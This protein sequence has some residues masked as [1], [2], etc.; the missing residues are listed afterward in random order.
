M[1]SNPKNE[2]HTFIKSV[3]QNSDID[4]VGTNSVDHKL[5]CYITGRNLG[6]STTASSG[7]GTN[8]SGPNPSPCAGPCGPS[9]N[10]GT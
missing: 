8:S 6:N 2:V 5:E 3:V 9:P 7:C 10:C 4:S 1:S